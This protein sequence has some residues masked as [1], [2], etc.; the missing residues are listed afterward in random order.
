MNPR[1]WDAPRFPWRDAML[2]GILYI[3]ATTA[4]TPWS[5]F[6]QAAL[7]IVA[8]GYAWLAHNQPVVIPAPVVVEHLDVFTTS[9]AKT[10]ADAVAVVRV[11]DEDAARALA[12]RVGQAFS[13]W[14]HGGLRDPDG[15]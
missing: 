7:S 9:I 13:E 3:A 11:Y 12:I 5:T 2:I 14:E 6:A 1:G 10:A 4:P 15:D 8:L